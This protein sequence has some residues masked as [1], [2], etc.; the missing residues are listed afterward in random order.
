MARLFENHK[1]IFSF[2][3]LF[4]LA[5]SISVTVISNDNLSDNISITSSVLLSL[6]LIVV[7][8]MICIDFLK[9]VC[10]P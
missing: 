4:L 7:F 6:G 8:A 1:V 2:G 9:S 10:N 3:I 5:C